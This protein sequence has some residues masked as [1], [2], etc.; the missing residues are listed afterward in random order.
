MTP[1]EPAP[2]FQAYGEFAK[3]ELVAQD[4]RKASFEQRGLAVITTSGALVTLLFAL[5]ALSTGESQTF[6]LPD[7]ARS[8]LDRALVLFFLAAVAALMTNVPLSYQAVE[9]DA[10]KARLN[11]TPIRDAHAAAK[12]I[13][14]TRVKALKSAKAKNTFKGRALFAGLAFEMLAVGCVAVAIVHVL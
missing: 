7:A 1:D 12:D 13:A 9:T 2:G 4:Q 3:D 8:R 5:A 14:L 11:E 10:I 6:V